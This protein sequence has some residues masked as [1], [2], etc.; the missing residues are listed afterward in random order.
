MDTTV[1]YKTSI[2]TETIHY[3]VGTDK[4]AF[5]LACLFF[6]IIGSI[7]SIA[8]RV[9]Q[10]GLR[11]PQTPDEFS[12]S[13]IIKDKAIPFVFGVTLAVIFMRLTFDWFGESLTLG[14][15]FLYGFCY[16]RLANLVP[17]VF[18][19]LIDKKIKE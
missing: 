6:V 18:G 16:Y 1:I 3:I 19:F 2:Y 11:N 12:W 7:L 9:L 17:K 13:Y 8:Q 15:S 5:V 14:L 4:T 10:T